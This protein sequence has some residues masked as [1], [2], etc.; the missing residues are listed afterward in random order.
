M[1][2]QRY[3]RTIYFFAEPPMNKSDHPTYWIGM[4][5]VIKEDIDKLKQINIPDNI[6]ITIN[7]RI[8]IRYCPFCGKN[9]PKFYKRIN[10]ELNDE[11]ISSEFT[12]G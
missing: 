10:N 4:R 2:E 5:S 3:G 8:P 11:T 9:I 12:G 7:T 1:F 6:P